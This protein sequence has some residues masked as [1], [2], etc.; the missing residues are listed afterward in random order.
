[1]KALFSNNSTKRNVNAIVEMSKEQMAKIHGGEVLQAIK[2]ANGQI[3]I[4]I[5]R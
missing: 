3:T 4:V 1:M 5:R 2:D